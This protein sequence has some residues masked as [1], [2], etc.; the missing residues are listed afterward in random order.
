VLAVL[1]EL[2][3]F[4]GTKQSNFRLL[5]ASQNQSEYRKHGIVAY[6]LLKFAQWFA[7]RQR[8]NYNKKKSAGRT[9]RILNG[10]NFIYYFNSSLTLTLVS[11]K[12]KFN[13]A[14]LVPA[15]SLNLHSTDDFVD[16]ASALNDE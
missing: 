14:G 13:A 10:E 11:S 15:G 7:T 12:N 6:Y 3:V 4:R 1:F 9:K 8:P 16:S 2:L 5:R